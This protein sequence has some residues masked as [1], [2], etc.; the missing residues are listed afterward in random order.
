MNYLFGL[1]KKDIDV[2]IWSNLESKLLENL[3]QKYFARFYRELFFILGTNRLLY[4]G[5]DNPI[6][7][8]PIRKDLDNIYARFPEYSDVNTLVVSSL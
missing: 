5:A 3:C 8:I 2:A 7:T 1:A 6:G 4:T